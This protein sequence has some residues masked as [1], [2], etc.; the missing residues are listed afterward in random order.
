MRPSFCDLL[1]YVGSVPT[2]N[3]DTFSEKL[4]ESLLKITEG[5]FDMKRMRMV[6]DRDQRQVLL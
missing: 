2:S 3:L 5:G 4:R 1:V 6:I